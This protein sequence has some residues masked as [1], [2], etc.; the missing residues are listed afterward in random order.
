MKD[1]VSIIIPFTDSDNYAD[2]IEML[3]DQSHENKEIICIV[4]NK[5]DLES[6]PNTLILE[7]E[8]ED[9]ET[10]WNYGL[11]DSNGEY[12]LFLTADSIIEDKDLLKN[13]IK[14]LESHDLDFIFYQTTIENEK[15][16]EEEFIDENK[17]KLNNDFK[18]LSINNVLNNSIFNHEDI[19]EVIFEMPSI[20]MN[21]IYRKEFLEKNNI[22]FKNS[23]F[24]SY[25]FY[26]DSILKADRIAYLKDESIKMKKHDSFNPN[27]INDISN[28]KNKN[29]SFNEYLETIIE[30]KKI[31]GDLSVFNEYKKSF[32]K[33][34][35]PHIFY[36]FYL[37]DEEE[38]EED[39]KII[40]EYLP[41]I[42]GEEEYLL[43][44]NAKNVLKDFKTNEYYGNT[45]NEDLKTLFKSD[46][47]EAFTIRHDK[48]LEKLNEEE[49]KINL[50][51]VIPV[52]NSQRYINECLDSILNQTLDNIEI[53][54]IDDRSTDNSF[55][56]LQYYANNYDNIKVFRNE[57]NKGAGFSRN[58]GLSYIKG[59]YFAFVDSDDF[60][61]ET[62]YE[63]VFN[64][65][66]AEDLD[67]AMF[68]LINY[69]DETGEVYTESYYDIKCLGDD[70]TQKVFNHK[71]VA[72]IGG[73]FKISVSPCNKIFNR[74]FIERIDARF[75]EGIS[76]EDNIFFFKIF[77]NAER[78]S[79][80]KEHLYYRRRRNDSVMGAYNENNVNVIFIS[81]IILD[82]F[83][84]E[85]Y[86]ELYKKGLLK[87]KIDV[88]RNRLKQT[89]NKHKPYFYKIMHEDFKKTIDYTFE[90]RLNEIDYKVDLKENLNKNDYK[91]FQDVLKYKEYKA[92]NSA[93]KLENNNKKLSKKN[94]KLEEENKK[95]KGKTKKIKKD[96][97]Y[98]KTMKGSVKYHIKKT[99]KK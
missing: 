10:A 44:Y 70:Y 57:E 77:L 32:Y 71:D 83:Q 25:L 40:K 65:V 98:L 20:P 51:I 96:L 78:V 64:L 5:S 68:Q 43:E 31:F 41:K 24:S 74:A 34:F 87:F 35:I 14:E 91:F 93:Q 12:V 88:C 22:S 15:N 13:T 11:N 92:F 53:I 16:N 17:I 86:Y 54:C 8:Y 9:L 82:L 66:K 90:R 45:I 36:Q 63:K 79:F 7:K 42:I 58:R 61:D 84:E 72:D 50:S 55:N 85:G 19:L 99:I 89:D 81:S 47:I 46:E 6:H 67:F 4:K 94:K 1:L 76:F 80:Y 60:L 49:E 52:Y 29:V 48:N 18:L 37:I 26:Y 56:I 95:L 39:F 59:D 21:K 30:I 38:R 23:I 75:K 3:N 28:L 62:A 27:D 33:K 73:I 2:Y 97:K 69:D